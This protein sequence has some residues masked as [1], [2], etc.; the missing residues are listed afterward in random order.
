MKPFNSS[1]LLVKDA[2][3]KQL[4]ETVQEKKS[5]LIRLL[6][7]DESIAQSDLDST[8]AYYMSLLK[9]AQNP[10]PKTSDAVCDAIFNKY[11]AVAFALNG[12]LY[13][14]GYWIQDSVLSD[15]RDFE[16]TVQSKVANLDGMVPIYG[17]NFKPLQNCSNAIIEFP[18]T[19]YCKKVVKAIESRDI[20]SIKDYNTLGKDFLN[21]IGKA[22]LNRD[23]IE[24]IESFVDVY[25][26][27]FDLEYTDV[28]GKSCLQTAVD[29]LHCISNSTIVN[30]YDLCSGSGANA[31]IRSL[32][33]NSDLFED[34]NDLRTVI[35]NLCDVLSIYGAVYIRIHKIHMDILRKVKDVNIS[36]IIHAI[37]AST[38]NFQE[39]LSMF[40]DEPIDSSNIFDLLDGD[41]FNHSDFM[42]LSLIADH[43]AAMDKIRIQKEALIQEAV[44]ISEGNIDQAVIEAG[45]GS[46][47]RDG[48]KKI[49]DFLKSIMN[50]FL[51]SIRFNFGNEKAWLQK[52]KNVILNNGFDP[53]TEVTFYSNINNALNQIQ[54]VIPPAISYNEL[55]QKPEA[56]TDENSFFQT[57][58]AKQ[59][60][61]MDGALKDITLDANESLANKCKWYLGAKLP[62]GVTRPTTFGKINITQMYQ[63]LL[64]TEKLAKATE[65]Q[66][67]IIERTVNNYTQQANKMPTNQTQEQ[68]KQQAGGES[69][70]FGFS[71]RVGTLLLEADIAPK[72]SG[73]DGATATPPPAGQ[74]QASNNN[75]NSNSNDNYKQSGGQAKEEIQKSGDDANLVAGRMEIYLK[76]CKAVL[77]AKATAITYAH[78]EML[79]VMRAIVKGKLG[80][81]AD[82]KLRSQNPES[83]TK[84]KTTPSEN[85]PDSNRHFNQDNSGN[86]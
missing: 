51:E 26:E 58:F 46:K 3:P 70:S 44:M 57:Y 13:S 84:G 19:D 34:P 41:D 20:S 1:V 7:F 31:L 8:K 73:A 68:P 50:K 32:K 49:L 67:K 83:E 66:L 29:T 53:A 85:G 61:N 37:E 45:I 82:I 86:G 27:L 35:Q 36:S 47:I 33:I 16:K 52:Y 75:N 63:W 79:D 22:I 10:N 72:N 78:K 55:R 28:Y 60:P 18:I 42:D 69:A 9:L 65:D 56:F 80:N 24:D 40:G 43:E 21:H 76:V 6:E 30:C 59:F 15:M 48:F 39:S 71:Y 81:S 62:D 23:G 12:L 54:K 17:A 38:D 25:T 2:S 4:L 74:S 14:D 5:P 11:E 64:E 77:S